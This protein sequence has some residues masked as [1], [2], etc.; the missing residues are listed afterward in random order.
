L[1]ADYEHALLRLLA[2]EGD[3][4]RIEPR[5]VR[6]KLRLELESPNPNVGI[7]RRLCSL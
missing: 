5:E 6:D 7:F 1:N 3:L 4:A 2:G